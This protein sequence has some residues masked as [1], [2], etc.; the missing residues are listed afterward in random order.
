MGSMPM[1]PRS[2]SR[3]QHSGVK[4]TN[5][6]GSCRMRLTTMLARSRVPR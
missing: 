6:L 5:Y 2:F 3:G 1:H 4:M